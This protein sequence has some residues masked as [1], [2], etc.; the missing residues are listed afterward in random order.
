MSRSILL[1]H[2]VSYSN[3]T[4]KAD[5]VALFDASVRS[6]ASVRLA[7]SITDVEKLMLN[8]NYL[9]SHKQKH[10]AKE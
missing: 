3:I 6:Q 1:A 8:R 4:K 10:Q 7:K 2:T 9:Q 5:L